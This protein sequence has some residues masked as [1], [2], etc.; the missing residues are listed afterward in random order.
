MCCGSSSA[1]KVTLDDIKKLT[2]QV[3]VYGDPFSS[4]VRTYLACLQYCSAKYTF[5]EIDTLVGENMEQ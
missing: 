3:T 2:K 4:D 5:N 1:Q